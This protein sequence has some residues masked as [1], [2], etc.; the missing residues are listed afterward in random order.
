MP[1]PTNLTP[2]ASDK[3]I[4]AA[5]GTFTE[6]GRLLIRNLTAAVGVLAPVDATYLVTSAANAAA[7]TAKVNLG[8]LA[9][10]YLKL[11]TAIGIGTPSTV[12]TIPQ[13][14]VTGLVAALALLTSGTYT[15]A[16]TNGANVAASTAFACQW[17]RVGA[18]VTVSGRVDVDPTLTATD[19]QLGIALPVASNF[20]AVTDCAGTAVAPTLS[21]ECAAILADVA[22]DR[23]LLQWKAVDV[24]N[25][26]RYFSFTYRVI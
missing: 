7:L 14:D 6:I 16:L 8:A 5:T 11:T 26:A 25:A 4:D 3:I 15:P 21:G 10:G 23:A 9:T 22:N 19:T 24:T 20:A 12:T 2:N 13:A 17:L 1:I 18:T